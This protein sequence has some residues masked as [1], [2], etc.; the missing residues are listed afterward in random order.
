MKTH[1]SS[2][3]YNKEKKHLKLQEK[4]KVRNLAVKHDSL[5]VK[6]YYGIPM[7]RTSKENE[8]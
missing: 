6:T 7:F 2:W 5:S 1:A 3:L 4:K 8:N